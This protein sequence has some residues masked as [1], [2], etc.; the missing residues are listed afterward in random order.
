MKQTALLPDAPSSALTGADVARVLAG[1]RLPVSNEAAMQSAI[2]LAFEQSGLPFQREV[3]RGADRIDFVVGTVGVECKV[4]FSVAEVNRQLARYAQWDDLT[5]LLLVTTV[6]RHLECRGVLNGKTVRV[7]I[8][9]G[10][11]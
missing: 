9:R 5:D 7:H 10:L 2:G 11:F 8:V 3:T 1:Y 4:Q 6:G